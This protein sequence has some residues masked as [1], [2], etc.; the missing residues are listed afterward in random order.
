MLF[1]ARTGSRSAQTC[2]ATTVLSVLTT[3]L[4]LVG[5]PV[6]AQAQDTGAATWS[7]TPATDSQSDGRPYLDY[8]VEPGDTYADAVAVMNLGDT[9]LD[10][11]VYAVDGVVTADGSFAIATGDDPK[12]ELG[13]WTQLA[14]PTVQVEPGGTAIVPF[15][16]TVPVNAEPGDH[17]GGI[18]ATVTTGEAGDGSAVVRENRVGTRF[19]VRVAGPIT[20]ELTFDHLTAHHEQSINPL[21][22]GD[23]EVTETLVNSGNLRLD[24]SR[25]IEVSGLFGWWHRTVSLEPTGD[26][27]PGNALSDTSVLKSVPPLGPLTV[28]V[29]AY[30][31]TSGVDSVQGFPAASRSVT[32]WAV[33]WPQAVALLLIGLFVWQAVSAQRRLRRLKVRLASVE[34]NI[35]KEAEPSTVVA[36]DGAKDTPIDAG[37]LELAA[38]SPPDDSP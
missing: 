37:G 9:P 1:L 17:F 12:T 32:V 30:P 38:D 27:L 33:P 8:V 22:F 2:A 3:F 20:P 10:L 26:L 36:A 15:T 21:R 23:V 7:I 25:S 24:A 28:T 34:K 13:A 18:V 5:W 4:V 31:Q 35:K 16:L 6:S 19:Y 29:H 11:A 14:V